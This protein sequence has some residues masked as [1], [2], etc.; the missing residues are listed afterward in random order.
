MDWGTE[1]V[2]AIESGDKIV[3]DVP[4]AFDILPSAYSKWPLDRFVKAAYD[5][6]L[7]LLEKMLDRDDPING[8]HYDMNAHMEEY[9]ALQSAALNGQLEAVEM[10]LAASA[11]PHMKASV[12][13]GKN[14]QDGETARDLADKW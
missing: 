2:L 10:L 3:W 9:N 14:P 8:F 5:G 12:P 11:D 13:M 6:D 4:A 7:E 1:G